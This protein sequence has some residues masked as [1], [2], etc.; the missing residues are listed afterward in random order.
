VAGW[1]DLRTN[2]AVEWPGAYVRAVKT[3]SGATAAVQIVYSS[4]R[5]SR[6]IEHI[7]SAHDDAELELLKAAA[8]QRLAARIGWTESARCADLAGQRRLP[9]SHAGTSPSLHGLR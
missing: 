1:S 3:A 5:G 4:H 9:G 7:S 8:R 6:D 2:P